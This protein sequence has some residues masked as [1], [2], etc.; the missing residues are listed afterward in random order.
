MS[1]LSTFEDGNP[2]EKISYLESLIRDYQLQILDLKSRLQ[3]EERRVSSLYFMLDAAVDDR[4]TK[5]ERLA[6]GNSK[7]TK[8]ERELAEI[9]STLIG[10]AN[11]VT[12]L[13]NHLASNS[14]RIEENNEN[15][16]STKRVRPKKKSA[17]KK[18]KNR[19]ILE[20]SKSS[21][22]MH[23]VATINDSLILKAPN[24]GGSTLEYGTGSLKNTKTNDDFIMGKK[25][26]SGVSNKMSKES[27]KNS[28]ESQTDGKL[29]ISIID[30]KQTD[31]SSNVKVSSPHINQISHNQKISTKKSRQ[32]S[33]KNKAEKSK[34]RYESLIGQEIVKHFPRFGKYTGVVNAYIAPYFKIYFPEDGDEEDMTERELLQYLSGR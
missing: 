31:Q 26:N 25:Q 21:K 34:N 32:N 8:L 2:C 30:K 7:I 12:P 6:L 22:K 4:L 16:T 15:A 24:R 5:D 27:V 14:N 19:K 23:D 13:P 11:D 3:T 18:L 10:N 20:I 28:V 33:T 29:N 9:K 1:M 17:H